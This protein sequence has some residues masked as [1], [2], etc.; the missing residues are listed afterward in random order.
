MTLGMATNLWEGLEP[1]GLP[2]EAA[3]EPIA[4]RLKSLAVP[5]STAELRFSTEE[6]SWLRSWFSQLTDTFRTWLNP[7]NRASKSRD[8]FEQ[9]GLLF[10]V[11]AA[12]TVREEGD[13]ESAWPV[14]Q[15]VF[16]PEHGLRDRLFR[17]GQPS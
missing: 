16:P 13:E 15:R 8:E 17:R 14:V 6:V 10:L 3:I 4:R 7:R 2:L 1:A 12:E 5:S 11:L 9:F